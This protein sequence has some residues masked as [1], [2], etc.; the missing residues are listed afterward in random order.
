[1]LLAVPLAAG[2]VAGWLLHRHQGRTGAPGAHGRAGDRDPGW[3]RTL[4]PAVLAGPVAG[5]LMG[6]AAVV[7]CGPIGGG[8][9]AEVGPAAWP[10]AGIA[11][12]VVAAGA[13]VT[14]AALRAVAARKS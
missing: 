4:A 5:A 10:L 12:V 14:V 9:L 1:V 8:R 2:M 6:L 13:T 7:S 3:L 11:A